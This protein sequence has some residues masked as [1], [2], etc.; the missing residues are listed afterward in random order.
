MHAVNSQQTRKPAF[1]ERLLAVRPLWAV[2][3]A[4]ATLTSASMTAQ[5]ILTPDTTPVPPPK[6]EPTPERP[7]PPTPPAE[8]PPPN[9]GGTA[10][11]DPAEDRR[12]RSGRFR[13]R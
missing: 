13:T 5:V 2:A 6:V 9:P 4:I 11:H 1:L 3:I 12:L 7:A 10:S 8:P